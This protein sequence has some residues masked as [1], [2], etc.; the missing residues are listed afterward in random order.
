[1]E[2]NYDCE[3]C[4]SRCA[5]LCDQCRIVILPDGAGKTPSL[6]VDKEKAVELD[7][8]GLRLS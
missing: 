3:R 1:M 4:A 7:E 8:E 6:Y 5:V 2:N